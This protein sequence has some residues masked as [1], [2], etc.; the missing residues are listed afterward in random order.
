M[1]KLD[2]MFN[3]DYTFSVDELPTLRSDDDTQIKIS[4]IDKF[5][6][7]MNEQKKKEGERSHHPSAF[8]E[9][10]LTEEYIEFEEILTRYQIFSHLDNDSH[11]AQKKRI[12]L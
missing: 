6:F 11:K 2:A 9:Y 12:E 8:F 3:G 5:R 7:R 10:R 1:K 4:W